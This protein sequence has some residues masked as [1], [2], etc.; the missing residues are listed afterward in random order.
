MDYLVKLLFGSIRGSA[1][2][3]L[4]LQEG[5]G[6]VFTLCWV[7]R[8]LISAVCIGLLVL[9]VFVGLGLTAQG[10]PYFVLLIPFGLLPEASLE[11]CD[12]VGD[13]YGTSTKT[14]LA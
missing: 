12:T 8:L 10:G 2:A 13:V 3:Q 1:N 6:F 11:I 4:P 14:A 7:M 9:G 5:S